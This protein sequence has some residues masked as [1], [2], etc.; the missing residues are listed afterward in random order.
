MTDFVEVFN[1]NQTCASKFANV[2]EHFPHLPGITV[3]LNRRSPAY[4]LKDKVFRFAC[5]LNT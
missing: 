1:K 2:I 4:T 5:R 3:F